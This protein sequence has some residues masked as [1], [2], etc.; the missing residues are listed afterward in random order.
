[1]RAGQLATPPF[2]E[3]WLQTNYGFLFLKER[4]LSPATHAFIDEVKAVK[5]IL[6]DRDRRAAALVA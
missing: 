6:V 1:V 2:T 4:A 3:P 5:A